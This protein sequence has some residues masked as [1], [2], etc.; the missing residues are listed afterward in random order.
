MNAADL[1]RLYG[2]NHQALHVN[3][4]GVTNEEAIVQPAPAGN[5]LNW[6]VGHIVASRNGVLQAIGEELIWPKEEAKRYARS[7]E[8][9]RGASDGKPL[10]RI[11]MDFDRSQER[12]QSALD[13]MTDTDLAQSR[14]DDD[15]VAGWLAFLH[16]HEAYHVG[17]TALLRRLIGKEGAIR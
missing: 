16:F 5:C 1:K 4:A 9:I 17:Q 12:I 15:T 3:V 7:S 8:P 13:R 11:L 2:I 14:G 10:D 6:V